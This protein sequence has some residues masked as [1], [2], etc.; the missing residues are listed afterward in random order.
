[1]IEAASN[2]TLK[3]AVSAGF[4]IAFMSAHAIGLEVEARRLAVLDVADFPVRRR[5]FTRAPRTAS[6]CRPW[7]WPSSSSCSAEGEAGILR[8]LPPR[9]QALLER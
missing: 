8:L 7:P 3:Q 4:G 9:A 5:W 2:E 6:T 1:M